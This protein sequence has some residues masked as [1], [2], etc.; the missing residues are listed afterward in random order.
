MWHRVDLVWTEVSGER[1]ASI[2]RVEKSAREEPA[3]AGGCSLLRWRWR[4]YVPP[5]HLL[6]QN[7]HAAISQK[8]AFFI[9]TAVKTSNLTYKKL[10]VWNFTALLVASQFTTM[11]L[12]NLIPNF[13]NSIYIALEEVKDQLDES[14]TSVGVVYYITIY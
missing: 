5:K 11:R 6:I 8:T 14:I 2:F 9:V 10:C 4:R 3:W 13:R 7:L 1:I 12:L